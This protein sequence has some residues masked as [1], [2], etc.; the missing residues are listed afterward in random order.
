MTLIEQI[1]RSIER[2]EELAKYTIS[3]DLKEAA[4][5]GIWALKEQKAREQAAAEKKAAQKPK[6]AKKEAKE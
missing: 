6:R 2:L 5:T 3:K 1:D 4:R